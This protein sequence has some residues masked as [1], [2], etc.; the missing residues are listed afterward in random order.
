MLND[1][2]LTVNVR[3]NKHYPV[4]RRTKIKI[5]DIEVVMQKNS[6]YCVTSTKFLSF[7]IDNKLKW[8]EN[9]V[10]NKILTL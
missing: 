7:I 4:F 8:N 3:K 1:N 2:K 6:I 9:I 10:Q 5:S